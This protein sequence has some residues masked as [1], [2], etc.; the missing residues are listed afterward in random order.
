M[1]NKIFQL[2]L[3][4]LVRKRRKIIVENE[5]K[6]WFYQ[7]NQQ[8]IKLS[9][10]VCHLGISLNSTTI[11]NLLHLSVCICM[12]VCPYDLSLCLCLPFHKLLLRSRWNLY[13]IFYRYVDILGIFST[14]TI[15]LQIW[16]L[17]VALHYWV[18]S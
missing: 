1:I 17:N 18:L 3:P 11:P 6:I 13:R 5:S 14:V 15:W 12:S 8:I 4:F 9:K 10:N 16:Y 2:F 7:Y